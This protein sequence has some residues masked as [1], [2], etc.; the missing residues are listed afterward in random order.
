MKRLCIIPARGNSK[1][2][3]RKNIKDFFGRP[4]ISFSIE[5]ALSSKL[6]DE[7]MVS[8]DD[9]DIKKVAINFGAKVPFMRSSENSNDFATTFN[10]IEEVIKEYKNIGIEYE[11]ICC[12]YPCAPLITKESLE[13]AYEKLLIDEFDSVFP[14]VEYSNPIQ[15]ALKIVG[16]NIQAFNPEYSDMRSQDLEKAYYDSGQFYWMRTSAILQFK[17][18]Y[19]PNS[20]VIVIDEMQ[21]Q[22]IDTEIDWELTKIKYKLNNEK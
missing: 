22:D 20:G 17:K 6:F 14:V 1:R 4:I 7:V 16:K 19:C 9:E 18:I 3:P 5:T 11:Y 8:T 10:V 15:R 13:K 12:I 21:A 2:I